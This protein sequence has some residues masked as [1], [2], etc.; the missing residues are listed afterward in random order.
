MNR[1]SLFAL[2]ITGVTQLPSSVYAAPLDALLSVN[3]NTTAGNVAIEASYDVVNSAVDVFRIRD[4]DADFS[5]TKIGDYH[6]AHLLAGVAVTPRLWLDGGLWQRQIDYRRD[7]AKIQSWQIAGQYKIVE[8]MGYRPSMAARLGTWG[9]SAGT[10][11]KTLPTQFQ[12]ATLNSIRVAGPKDRQY[13]L[14]L[15]A[16]W[17]V[18]ESVE[19]TTFAGAGSSRVTIDSIS[20]T[21]TQNGCNY[22]LA[23][24][25]SEVTGTLAQP[26]S[27][28]VVVE[29]F[30]VSN[31]VYGVDV[32]NETQY[33]ARYIHG[34]L[35][36]K[37]TSG[38]W[39]LR[40]GY[41]YQALKRRNVDDIIER[42]GGMAN[43]SNHVLIGELAY[44]I[45]ANISLFGR[46]QYMSN[47]FTGEVPLAYNTF[48]ARRFNK[49]YGIVSA[50][51][52][53]NF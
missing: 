25:R 40:V 26:C 50:G 47:Q 49:R 24:G 20:G 38:P 6:G 12:G 13:Q 39:Q 3:K 19:V 33:S 48:T 43:K 32:Y 42:R 29:R 11:D 17:P 44:K 51:I 10:L 41:Q 31:S 16:S 53:V 23:F 4:R 37:W 7:Q 21:T 1:S 27:G 52:A 35:S 34:G 5:G 46:G 18:S 8:A 14:D 45:T 36:G 2:F 28:S 22:N 15:I 30:T 9:N